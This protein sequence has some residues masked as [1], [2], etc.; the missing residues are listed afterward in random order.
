MYGLDDASLLWYKTVE[1]EV[2]R[3]GRKKLQSDPAIFYFHHPKK[4]EL[5]G[6]VGWHVDDTNGGGRQPVLL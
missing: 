4:K 5:E 6:M 1:E 3:L 2:Y